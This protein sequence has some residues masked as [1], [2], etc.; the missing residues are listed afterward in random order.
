VVS[1]AAFGNFES[2]PEISVII[3]LDIFY[4]FSSTV[5]IIVNINP[6]FSR[7]IIATDGKFLPGNSP[8]G[9]ERDI[10]AI[11]LR[12]RSRQGHS[13]KADHENNQQ[14]RQQTHLTNLLLAI[15][16]ENATKK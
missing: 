8:A 4:P 15:I 11:G 2:N 14:W 5:R 13:H 9:G 10:C 3:G 1:A 16:D 12:G 7:K 6:P